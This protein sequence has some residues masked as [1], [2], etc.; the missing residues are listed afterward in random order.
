M[1]DLDEYERDAADGEL[2]WRQIVALIA[3]ARMLRELN[4]H[5]MSERTRMAGEIERLCRNGRMLV[6]LA[7][8]AVKYAREDRMVT[9]GYTRLRRVLDEIER[10]TANDAESASAQLCPF[11]CGGS[12]RA[13]KC[14]TCAGH[15]IEQIADGRDWC[16]ECGGAGSWMECERDCGESSTPEPA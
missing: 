7:R 12:W 11:G 13:V 6:D 3:E 14:S 1:I 10:V 4:E 9:H 5:S 2:H 16:S 8:R 15:G